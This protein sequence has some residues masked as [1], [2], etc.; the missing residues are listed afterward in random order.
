MATLSYFTMA[1]CAALVAVGAVQVQGESDRQL[2]RRTLL[3]GAKAFSASRP[4]RWS[5][6]GTITY[7]G[8]E[9]D[10]TVGWIE[11]ATGH[12]VAPDAGVYRFT[13][14]GQMVC[15]AGSNCN[16]E[17]LLK[18]NDKIKKHFYQF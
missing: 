10:T 3:Q 9:V 12:F 16:G 8:I 1:L 14:T 11:Q 18:T 6:D 2:Y 4:S 13:F 5:D 17:I 7:D 15:P